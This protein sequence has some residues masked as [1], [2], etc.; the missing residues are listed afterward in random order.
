[1]KRVTL[2]GSTG[3]IGTQALEIIAEN[4]E[5]FVVSGLAA[6]ANAELIAEQATRF[7][8]PL[9]ALED[10]AAAARAKELVPPGVT[11]LAGPDGVNRVAAES[12]ADVC[13]AAMVGSA[14]LI[15][16]L[17]AIDAG[18][19]IALANKETLVCAGAL[20]TARA[21]EKGVRIIP[22]DSEHSALFQSLAGHDRAHVRRLILTASGGPFFGR[23]A[24]ELL[25]VTP[26]EAVKH[27]RW[28]M[29]QKISVDSATLMNKALEIIEARWLFDVPGSMISVVIHPQSIVHSMVEY[30]DGSIIAQLGV[31]DMRIPIGYALGYPERIADQTRL[32][33]LPR[34]A[35]G[36][37]FFE[38]DERRFV[39]LALAHRALDRGGTM[40]AVLSAANESAVG[41]FLA[42]AI[43]FPSIVK[44][45]EATMD[46]HRVIENPTLSDLIE[47]D[48]WAR[49]ETE[50]IG[51]DL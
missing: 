3:S 10:E 46:R 35:G 26:E 39:P 40:S 17:A 24:E 5:R 9:I 27:P 41:M 42:R 2:L 31:T 7:R 25:A 8:S 43:S 11:V 15:P 47:T 28:K 14:G 34:I 13:L 37:T 22:V 29:G 51:A 36:L 32:L 6:R 21:R 50:R 45:V 48:R 20:V 49:E 30:V 44:A 19:D 4:P 23:R 33:D 1:M 38:A 12:G 18:I 16:T